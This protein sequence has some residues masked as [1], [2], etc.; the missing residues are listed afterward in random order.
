MSAYKEEFHFYKC[1]KANISTNAEMNLFALFVSEKINE[2]DKEYLKNGLDNDLDTLFLFEHCTRLFVKNNGIIGPD[3][4]IKYIDTVQE[5][6]FIRYI[7]RKHHY[8]LNIFHL[9]FVE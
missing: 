8:L 6:G 1:L 5:R 7:I 4:I 2:I 3:E 9:F